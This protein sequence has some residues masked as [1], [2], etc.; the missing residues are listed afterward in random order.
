M[1]TKKIIAN[2]RSCKGMKVTVPESGFVAFDYKRFAII[3]RDCKGSGRV[4]ISYEEPQ[5]VE[6]PPSIEII[7]SE[8]IVS[9]LRKD[10]PPYPHKTGYVTTEEFKNGKYPS[11]AKFGIIVTK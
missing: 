1:E 10:T 8:E 7:C 11:P 6:I 5:D 2:C 9:F 4:E 3:C